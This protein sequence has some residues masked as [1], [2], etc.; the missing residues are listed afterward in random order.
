[1]FASG[2]RQVTLTAIP[3]DQ[4]D[5]LLRM[6][7]SK[8]ASIGSQWLL[9]W[10]LNSIV[11]TLGGST[12]RFTVPSLARMATVPY[13]ASVAD[14]RG[15][16]AQGRA[17]V[18]VLPTP[19]PGQPPSG[20][21]T[22]SPTSAPAGSTVTVNFPVSDPEGGPVGWDMV[23]GSMYV[24]SRTC[25]FIGSSTTLRLNNAGAYRIGTQA[26]DS[27]L[28][29]SSRSSVVVRIGGATGEPPIANAT[30]D[31]LSGPAPLKVNFDMSGS[32]DP[33]G[34]KIPTYLVDCGD[35]MLTRSRKPQVSCSFNKPGTYWIMLLVQDAT[36]YV[37]QI[38]TYVV[39]TP[40]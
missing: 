15:G 1:V 14:G 12:A 33:D 16:A 36:G 10:M 22:V 32:V 9:G 30:A 28:N 13:D 17:Y 20:S 6:S 40:Q 11:P 21:L 19:S 25:C 23:V 35:R 5:D 24:A 31:K 39:A 8:S 29:L 18:T 27:E 26:I 37:D 38:S 7:W 4:D 34:S 2:G 3:A